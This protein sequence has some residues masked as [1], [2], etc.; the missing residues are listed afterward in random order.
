MVAGAGRLGV[1]HATPWR[2]R[3]ESDAVGTSG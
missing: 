3:V 2:V 1:T